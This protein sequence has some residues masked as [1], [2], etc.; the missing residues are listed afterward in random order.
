MPTTVGPRIQAVIGAGSKEQILAVAAKTCKSGVTQSIGDLVALIGRQFVQEDSTDVGVE[1]LRISDP[2]AIRRPH[3]VEAALRMVI[4]I[5]IH[6]NRPFLLQVDV[7]E[8]ERRAN[9][10][11]PPYRRS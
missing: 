8:V 7:I 3:G 2:F 6:V 10:R 1:A 4:G 5:C 9:Y 11:W